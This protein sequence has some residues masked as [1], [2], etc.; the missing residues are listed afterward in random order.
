MWAEKPMNNSEVREPNI[1]PWKSLQLSHSGSKDNREAP[2]EVQSWCAKLPIALA[3]CIS[4]AKEVSASA[5]HHGDV[6]WSL[7]TGMIAVK[8]EGLVF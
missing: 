3:P 8:L 5:Y 2:A 7:V 1:R 6:T 4:R